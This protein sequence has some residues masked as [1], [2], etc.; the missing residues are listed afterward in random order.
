MNSFALKKSAFVLAVLAAACAPA[1]SNTLGTDDAVAAAT[2]GSGGAGGAVASS[3]SAVVA[4][5]SSTA[6]VATSAGAGGAGGAASGCNPPAAAGS[7][8]ALAAPEF[9]GA[10]D[11]SMCK[12]RGDVLLIVDTA[13][14]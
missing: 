14:L 7:L 13:A 3:S 11:V 9:G 8:Y 5:S 4:S 10:G 2:S 6:V 1:P 12:W